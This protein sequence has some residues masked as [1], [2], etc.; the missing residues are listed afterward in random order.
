MY[1]GEGYGATGREGYG[2]GG[3]CPPE[4]IYGRA[5]GGRGAG[6]Y[7][8]GEVG[9]GYGGGYGG[10][11]GGGYGGSMEAGD[12]HRGAM[13]AEWGYAEG[14]GWEGRGEGGALGGIAGH[15]GEGMG[16]SLRRRG[17]GEMGLA[18]GEGGEAE[19]KG[20]KGGG[21]WRLF[22]GRKGGTGEKGGDVGR[23]EQER[24]EEGA[25]EGGEARQQWG[26]GGYGGYPLGMGE[27]VGG[28]GYGMYTGGGYGTHAGGGGEMYGAG[29]YGAGA[30]GEGG[31]G[32]EGYGEGGNGA[33][34]YGE[35]TYGEVEWAGAHEAGH[36]SGVVRGEG[37]VGSNGVAEL[38][39]S[40]GPAAAAA[41]A[42][43]SAAGA[44]GSA[45]GASAAGTGG[46]AEQ[47]RRSSV[48]DAGE[49]NGGAAVGGQEREGSAGSG[50][51]LAGT[52]IGGAETQAARAA[53]VAGAGVAVEGV[54]TTG[55]TTAGFKVRRR[56]RP[57]VHGRASG[58]DE[59]EA[60]SPGG[61]RSGAAGWGVEERASVKGGD[62]SVEAGGAGSEEGDGGDGESGESGEERSVGSGDGEDEEGSKGEGSREG[63]DGASE[64]EAREGERAGESR[65]E[66]ECEASPGAWGQYP[67]PAPHHYAP[68]HPAFQHPWEH[69][70]PNDPWQ[71]HG[72]Q[73]QGGHPSPAAHGSHPHDPWQ[74][75]GAH[76][77]AAQGAY[78]AAHHPLPAAAAAAATAV[79]P[80]SGS[81]TP[82]TRSPGPPPHAIQP[83]QGTAAGAWGGAGVGPWGG[84]WGG[85]AGWGWGGAG[86][87]GGVHALRGGPGGGRGGAPGSRGL[88]RGRQAGGGNEKDSGSDRGEGE[89][90]GGAGERK[91]RACSPEV[92]GAEGRRRRAGK[93]GWWAVQWQLWRLQ[94]RRSLL[95]QGGLA[96]LA[97]LLLAATLASLTALWAWGG[98]DG[99]G[100]EQGEGGGGVG[101]GEVRT[102][103]GEG[104][105]VQGAGLTPGRRR[106]GRGR[107]E[108]GKGLPRVALGR[109]AGAS[110]AGRR[111]TDVYE[112]SSVGE[113]MGEWDE[114]AGLEVHVGTAAPPLHGD[115]LT[116]GG[117][118]SGKGGATAEGPSGAGRQWYVA[119]HVAHA[120]QTWPRLD[121]SLSDAFQ[122]PSHAHKWLEFARYSGVAHVFWYDMAD[123][124]RDRMEVALERYE[125]DGFITYHHFPSL[126]PSL[127]A[128]HGASPRD[129]A[130]HHCLTHH[131][132]SVVW[133]LPLTPVDYLSV[134]P[135]I[136]PGFADR[137]LRAYEARRPSAS[138]LLLQTFLFLGFPQNASALLI[139][140]YQRRTNHSDGVSLSP[141]ARVVPVV[142][143]DLVAR[144][145]WRNPSH[146]LMTGGS[147]MAL[148]AGAM[149]V[150]RFA[151]ALQQMPGTGT[152]RGTDMVVDTSL[153]PLVP[154]LAM[155]LERSQQAGRLKLPGATAHG[156]L[157][158]FN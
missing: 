146:L 101:L 70:R 50:A 40:H 76:S 145:L 142:R 138:Q 89:G 99:G 104:R 100:G 106:W 91:G 38:G 148:P 140:R 60:W 135:D 66:W 9:W 34:G 150:N 59:D 83:P 84:G 139:Q 24:W 51:V 151:S 21:W 79:A 157:G 103:G 48:G 137:F 123:D 88:R 41:G 63:S 117:E 26:V 155:M 97:L 156:T 23:G 4:E 10:S 107:G 32:A 129:Q 87:E 3:G 130:L 62:G 55:L 152:Q 126:A 12:G 158:G 94:P 29:G 16:D 81:H 82:L 31:Y 18:E 22:G 14:S 33:W 118:V 80:A 112:A 153:Q 72:R 37:E 141:Q 56:G 125:R 75:H 132:S 92:G 115:S 7:G 136:K 116:S 105:R 113:R 13:G 25:G 53:G 147:T 74:Q 121:F 8:G 131:G 127:P 71:T 85:A 98:G 143:P 28:W 44:S 47:P 64:G 96:A 95:L 78:P 122:V 111:G 110:E 1:G 119:V 5:Y 149:R 69:Q 124:P 54:M 46:G 68:P 90:R 93:A 20:K 58:Y 144:V 73:A 134:P 27:E 11:Y 36:Y 6:R 120:M 128:H 77:H 57:V 61:D 2:G 45:A 49:G 114:Q 43:G 154:E 86:G 19:E 42:S 39:A 108:R 65:Q 67:S 15:G 17:N 133:L 109:A 52:A 30:Y 102:W 35:G